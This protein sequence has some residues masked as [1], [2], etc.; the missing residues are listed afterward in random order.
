MLLL[1]IGWNWPGEVPCPSTKESIQDKR[2]KGSMANRIVWWSLKSW[3]FPTEPFQLN[4]PDI[5]TLKGSRMGYSRN[6]KTTKLGK[7]G[8]LKAL[9]L[10][11]HCLE[12]CLRFQ[13]CQL[14]ELMISSS[15]CLSLLLSSRNALHRPSHGFKKMTNKVRQSAQNARWGM[16]K[17]NPHAEVSMCKR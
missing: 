7:I 1:F 16:M 9:Y 6:K 15:I 5:D 13:I 14:T 17:L 4:L 3:H 11:W 12:K 2:R 10:N 8:R